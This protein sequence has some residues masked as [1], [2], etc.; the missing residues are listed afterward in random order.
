[1]GQNQAVGTEVQRLQQRGGAFVSDAYQT[2]HLRR[3]TGQQTTI[4]AAL[5]EG[6]VLGVQHHCIQH[7]VTGNFHHRMAW[8]FDERADQ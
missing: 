7:A 1:M 2:G 6:R 4:K 3:A 8:C 5:I